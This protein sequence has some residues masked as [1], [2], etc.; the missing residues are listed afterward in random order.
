MPDAI[1]E[2][3]WSSRSA[4]VPLFRPILT[5]GRTRAAM[6]GLR[7]L[8]RFS[9]CRSAHRI[10]IGLAESDF[11]R[12]ERIRCQ[13][14]GGRLNGSR[15][16]AGLSITLVKQFHDA[17]SG[18]MVALPCPLDK[19]I[20]LRIRYPHRYRASCRGHETHDVHR[21]AKNGCEFDFT[22]SSPQLGL[23]GDK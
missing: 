14:I 4:T 8:I 11:R 6:T 22:A 9:A 10:A 12:R 15:A 2:V 13:E 3:A 17:R 16:S 23:Q 18:L 7:K 5:S 1:D 19:R 21:R 20:S